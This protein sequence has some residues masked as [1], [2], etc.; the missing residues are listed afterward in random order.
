M[1]K[2]LS[3]EI[4]SSNIK[5][6][7][8]DYPSRRPTIYKCIEIDTPEDYMGDVIGD[9]NSRRGRLEGMEARGNT[10][11][12]RGFVPLSEM[13]GYATDLRSKTQGRG[14]YNMQSDHFEEI[15]RSIAEE[16]IAKRKG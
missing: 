3:I 2:V 16:I 1:A 7:E 12:I 8:M 15:P 5:I 9:L 6:A 14:T 13:F 4:G 11:V 10:Q